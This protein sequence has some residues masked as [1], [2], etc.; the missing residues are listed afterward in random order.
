MKTFE[1]N[2][3]EKSHQQLRNTTEPQDICMPSAFT[4]RGSSRKSTN[5]ICGGVEYSEECFKPATFCEINFAIWN[6][7]LSQVGAMIPLEC[8]IP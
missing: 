7:Q 3:T 8:I 5:E 2:N 4:L 6:L 1:R